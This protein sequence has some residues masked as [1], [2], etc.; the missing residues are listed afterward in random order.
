MDLNLTGKVAL[1]TG[2]GSGIGRGICL[3]LVRH[4]A[5][6][7]VADISLEGAEATAD[8]IR[9]AGGTA[10]A[11]R[12]DVA[13]AEQVERM[14]ADVVRRLGKIDILCNNAGISL[15]RNIVDLDEKDWD[16]H[17]DINAKGVYLCSKAVAKHMIERG[18]GG[19]I[20][21]TASYLGKI[22]SPGLGH[23]CAS[24]FAVVGLTQCLACELGPYNI[25]VNSVCP[26]DVDTPM[27]EREWAMHARNK[28]ITPR[29]AKEENRRRM[30]LGRLERPEDVANLVLFLASD[31]A[32]Y[33]TG[34]SVNVSGGLPFTRQES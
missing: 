3:K 6:V 8:E 34:E 31:L 23:Y 5:S 33:I 17:M 4:G 26:G 28:G 22:G 19:R 21:N 10:I 11:E 20:I 18:A 16:S 25:T 12:V 27:M 32:D 24:K 9:K 1:V 2:G 14:V 30:L 13:S 15:I 29:E 7:A